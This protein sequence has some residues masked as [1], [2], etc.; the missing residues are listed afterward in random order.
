ML[1]STFARTSLLAIFAAAL[2]L[3]GCASR[4][5]VAKLQED[6]AQTRREADKSATAAAMAQQ[7]AVAA[8]TGQAAQAATAA[9]SE[10]ALANQ[11]AEQALREANE[12][13]AAAA[14]AIVPVVPSS[15]VTVTEEIVK[16]PVY[17]KAGHKLIKR[18]RIVHETY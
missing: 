2:G 17:K 11:K 12:A 8:Q 18:K 9:Q 13:R 10:A 5:T 16:K 4:G 1:R 14:T 7:A 6:L 3:S 15:E